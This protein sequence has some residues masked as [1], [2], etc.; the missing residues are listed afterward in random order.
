MSRVRRMSSAYASACARSTSQPAVVMS[1]T[2][3]SRDTKSAAV[4][5]STQ[6][7]RAK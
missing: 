6:Y 3:P 5:S 2:G 1:T 4:S 7:Q